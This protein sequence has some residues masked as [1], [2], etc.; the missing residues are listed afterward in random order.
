MAW[1]QRLSA[2]RKDY[3]AAYS[4]DKAKE[5]FVEHRRSAGLGFVRRT[6]T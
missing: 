4:G 6:A 2:G 5:F 3:G 1:G